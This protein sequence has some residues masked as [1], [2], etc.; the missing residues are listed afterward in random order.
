VFKYLS[1]EGVDFMIV[2]AVALL[3]GVSEISSGPAGNL[4]HFSM[5][6]KTGRNFSLTFGSDPNATDGF[7]QAFGEAPIPPSPPPGIF[8]LR[9]LDRPGHPRVP[10]DGS[11]IDIRPFRSD[12]QVDT[13]IVHFQ[14]ANE[15][16][17][18]TFS[19][20]HVRDC[21]SAF[22]QCRIGDSILRVN[23]QKQKS[24]QMD[25][26]GESKLVIICYGAR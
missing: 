10:G 25:D 18:I 21:D 13:F 14:T 4:M 3:I 8:E 26:E 7:D 12:T 1:V 11:Y 2:V 24:L 16:Y 20:D 17:P 23:M 19:W 6:D 15:A 22:V 9:F 5:M